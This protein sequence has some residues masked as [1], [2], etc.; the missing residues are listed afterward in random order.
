MRSRV[1]E[2]ERAKLL[3]RDEKETHLI[4]L[5]VKAK[6]HEAMVKGRKMRKNKIK[7]NVVCHAVASADIPMVITWPYV[8]SH[9]HK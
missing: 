9:S 5:K 7:R 3:N 4:F 6:Q 2:K 8:H 1:R